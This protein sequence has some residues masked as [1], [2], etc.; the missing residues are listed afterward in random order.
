MKVQAIFGP[1]GTGKTTELIG[2]AAK[3]DRCIFLSYTRAAATEAASRITK[4][5]HQN[6]RASTIHSLAF[7]ALNMN[8]A[9]I[10][11]A[12]KLA[13][14]A[15]DT[16]IPFKGSEP[17][18]DEQQEGDEYMAVMQFARNRLMGIMD[19]YDHFGC[20]GTRPR[21][22]M[23]VTS[24]N[25]WKKAF[26]YM[27]FDDM[28]ELLPRMTAPLPFKKGTPIFLDEAQDCSSL[29]WAAFTSICTKIAPEL[30]VIAGDDDQAVFE[31]SGADPH[32][33]DMFIKANGGEREIL[34]QSHRLPRSVHD[35]AGRVIAGIRNRVHK[36]FRPRQED[37]KVTR[38]GGIEQV[39]D[40]LTDVAEGG[41]LVLMRDRFKLEEI[42]KMMNR[43]LIPYEVYGGYSP[44][45]SK[46]ANA[47]RKREKVEIP[48]AWQE[49]YAQADLFLP[50]KYALST[51]HSA[52]GREH[53]TVVMDLE[54]PARVLGNI[55]LDPDAETRV[56]YVGLTRAKENLILC[57]HNPIV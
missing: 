37:G 47:L 13:K 40:R 48:P 49:F 17:G 38:W 55:A 15:H 31:W 20:P 9:S 5:G 14:F 28:L 33:M 3:L 29:Q 50:I 21:F 7:N 26:G 42:K 43:D 57:G 12:V 19:A 41:A 30:V 27:D 56:Q 8:R 2:R 6:I 22:T 54:C 10:V 46:I 32:G 34:A 25:D 45:T 51:V 52:K 44:W 18:S 23:C 1:P 11:D 24:Y 16:G 53:N 36:Q 4:Y 35:Y 39:I